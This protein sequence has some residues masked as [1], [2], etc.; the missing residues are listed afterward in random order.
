MLP[1]GPFE[2][3]IG[4]ARESTCQLVEIGADDAGDALQRG[5]HLAAGNRLAE[6][7]GGETEGCFERFAGG[8]ENFFGF[9]VR[10]DPQPGSQAETQVAAGADA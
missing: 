4:E 9:V 1:S 2:V 6:G 8:G 10:G 3:R 5:Q 7:A